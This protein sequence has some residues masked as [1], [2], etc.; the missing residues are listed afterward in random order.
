MKIK[1]IF[2]LGLVCLN[3]CDLF[4]K[5]NSD[6]ILARVNS[7]ILYKTDLIKALPKDFSKEDSI[8][9]AKNF[10]DKWA[11]DKILLDKAK[12]NLPIKEQ[13]RYQKMV[14]E[15]KSELFKKAYLDA[16]LQKETDSIIDSLKIDQYYENYKNVFKINEHLLKLRY[17][18][19]KNNLKN[20]TKIKQSFK[21]FN[22]EDKDFL[23]SEQLKFDKIKLNDSVWVK[24]LDVYKNLENLNANQYKNLL[25]KN[26]YVEIQ[27]S[28]S[29]YFI[30]VKDVLKP[31]SI[32]PKSYIRPTIEQILRN[33]Q[34][35]KMKKNLEQQILDDAI[36]NNNYEIL[37]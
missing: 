27:D 28:V 37:Q 25:S 2:I 34:K 36:K 7:H 9:F 10:I 4:K 23:I 24:S 1:L 21:R 3:S 15:Y 33:K 29:T 16:L 18:Y 20:Y 5:Q 11:M 26:R 8:I 14:E 6:D 19:V 31:N 17:L 22:Q 30:Y 35:L 32:A 13:E 12:F